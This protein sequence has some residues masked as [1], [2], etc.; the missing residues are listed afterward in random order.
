MLPGQRDSIAI[1]NEDEHRR[2]KISFHGEARHLYVS[3]NPDICFKDIR[4]VRA[5]TATSGDDKS[6]RIRPLASY[7]QR[8]KRGDA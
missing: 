4:C 6:D 3:D 1:H 5:A 8:S 7:L 2:V